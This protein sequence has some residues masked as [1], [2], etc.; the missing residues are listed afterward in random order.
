[1]TATTT[2]TTTTITRAATTTSLDAM[3][4]TATL[5]PQ[6]IDPQVAGARVA[7]M[8]ARHGRSLYGLC[9]ML[10]RDP[11]EAEDALQSTFLSAHRALLRGGTPRDEVAW[12]VA[13]ARNECRGRI[14]TRMETPVHGDA[15]AIE[16]LPDPRPTPE[17]LLRDESVQRALGSLPES[18]REAVVLH[19]VLG[20]RSREIGRVLGVSVPAVEA[21]LFR[22]RRQLRVRLRPTGALVLPAAVGYSLAQAIPGFVTPAAAGIAGATGGAAGAGIVAKLAATPTAAKVAAGI[23]AAA[24][25]GSVTVVEVT[26]ERAGRPRPAPAHAAGTLPVGHVP[27]GAGVAGGVRRESSGTPHGD[28]EDDDVPGRSADEAP[29]EDERRS[30]REHD[31]DDDDDQDHGN[32]APPTQADPDDHPSHPSG[33][34]DPDEVEAAGGDDDKAADGRS[35]PDDGAGEEDD[36]SE[37]SRPRSGESDDEPETSGE[38]AAGE[39]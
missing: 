34:D 35:S 22:A 1:M 27:T 38:A 32:G 14:R 25:A 17:E 11:H 24:T 15:S 33:A 18:Q 5:S 19:D 36:R 16:T 7:R 13:I 31:D 4:D 3:G 23:A 12:L 9:R 37:S 28:D 8:Y 10:L 21:L 2:T 20:L 6:P 29:S 26:H 30:D 39:G